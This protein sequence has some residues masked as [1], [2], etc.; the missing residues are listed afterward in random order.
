MPR[1]DTPS[2][3]YPPRYFVGWILLETGRGPY[4]RVDFENA[5]LIPIS[6]HRAHIYVGDYA[7]AFYGKPVKNSRL[8]GR[9][10]E[11]QYAISAL[12][13]KTLRPEIEKFNHKFKRGPFMTRDVDHFTLRMQSHEPALFMSLPLH[14]VLDRAQG[15]AVPVVQFSS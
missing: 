2:P 1:R 5:L 3:M 15:A 6:T 12:N 11:I 13:A 14:D 10:R 8:Y 9:V 7:T 4:L